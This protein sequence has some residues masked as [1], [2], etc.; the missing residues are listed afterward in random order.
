[1]ADAVADATTKHGALDS[2]CLVCKKTT[3][4]LRRCAQ[5]KSATYCSRR[6]QR[7]DWKQHKGHCQPA[8]EPASCENTSSTSMNSQSVDSSLTQSSKS[9]PLEKILFKPFT[10]LENGTYLH[11]RP[12]HDVY[13]LLVDAFRLRENDDYEFEGYKREGSVYNGAENSLEPFRWFLRLAENRSGLLPDWWNADTRKACEELGMSTEQGNWSSLKRRVAKRN[14]IRRYE[15]D[16]TMPMQL[17]M[18]AEVVYK[19]G[20]TGQDGSFMLRS[21]ARSENGQGFE[22]MSMLSMVA[23][24]GVMVPNGWLNNY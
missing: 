3:V 17:R 5:C 6:C 20:V 7:R 21:M 10:R 15:D 14:I 16:K 13:K 22:C 8:P 18:I 23:R 4:D 2:A 12:K 11:D 24:D 1:M 19:R 9:R